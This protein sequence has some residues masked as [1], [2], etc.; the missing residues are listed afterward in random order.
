MLVN[1]AGRRR[2]CSWLQQ[3][4]RNHKEHL[5]YIHD[6]LS[7]GI[8]FLARRRRRLISSVHI[9]D[10]RCFCGRYVVGRREQET[11]SS[12]LSRQIW[13]TSPSL[14]RRPHCSPSSFLWLISGILLCPS[15]CRP[16]PLHPP[17]AKYVSKANSSLYLP[18]TAAAGRSP[19]LAWSP[20]CPSTTLQFS[21]MVGITVTILY[22]SLGQASYHSTS[23]QH[24]QRADGGNTPN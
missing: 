4:L 10:R 22:Y 17:S 15:L 1:P 21:P 11:S 2:R 19:P 8:F 18:T 14:T 20:Q 3:A 13:V 24:V 7:A 12:L 6:N 9:G 23:K 16:L 5:S